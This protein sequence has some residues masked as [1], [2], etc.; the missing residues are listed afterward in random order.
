MYAI[1]INFILTY[2]V[3]HYK[4]ITLVL[5]FS[6]LH[7]LI[8]TPTLAFEE[9][10]AS[11]FCRLAFVFGN[12]VESFFLFVLAKVVEEAVEDELLSLGVRGARELFSPLGV[13]EEVAEDLILASS[14]SKAGAR[15]L[16]TASSSDGFDRDWAAK[17]PRRKSVRQDCSL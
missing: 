3:F 6:Y 12:V 14:A 1:L 7:S 4:N 10:L 11:V 16:T 17:K 2:C 9:A 15:L 13:S 5:I 8:N